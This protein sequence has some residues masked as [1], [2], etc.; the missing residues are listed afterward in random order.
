MSARTPRCRCHCRSCGQHFASLEAFDAHRVGDFA[1]PNGHP[2]GRRCIAAEDADRFGRE[3]GIC[4]V[5]GER[6][7]GGSI[8]FLAGPRERVK[9]RFH[10]V[11]PSADEPSLPADERQVAI[12]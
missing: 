12:D 8:F 3:V 1:R 2:D 9:Q 10:G 7:E 11:R 6:H 4:V 5:T